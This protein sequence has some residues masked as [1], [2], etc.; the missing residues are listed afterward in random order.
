MTWRRKTGRAIP[1]PPR[2]PGLSGFETVKAPK[3]PGPWTLYKRQISARLTDARA[4]GISI[5][6]I[7]AASGGVLGEHW[8]MDALNAGQLSREEWHA[9]ERALDQT[10]AQAA[11]K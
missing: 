2:K 7:A 5:A 4:A 6:S 1:P 10:A 8:V 9:L 3:K 11:G